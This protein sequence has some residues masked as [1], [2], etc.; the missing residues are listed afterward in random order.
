MA[1]DPATIYL[2]LFVVGEWPNFVVAEILSNLPVNELIPLKK[3][4][5]PER[6]SRAPAEDPDSP[7]EEPAT[8][9]SSPPPQHKKRKSVH[10]SAELESRT[11]T[12]KDIF[13]TSMSPEAAPST[14]SP[15]PA[16][17]SSGKRKPALKMSPSATPAPKRTSLPA[18]S[19]ATSSPP[20]EKDEDTPPKYHLRSTLQRQV[21]RRA[22]DHPFLDIIAKPP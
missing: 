20:P 22:F 18:A 4:K 19:K 1:I 15:A 3:R 10:W 9:E 14:S 8:A 7:S 16:P 13:F 12:A 2:M 17:A 11:P 5:S 6:Q 21:N